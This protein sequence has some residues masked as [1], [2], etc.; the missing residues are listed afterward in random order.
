MIELAGVGPDSRVRFQATFRRF[1]EL[2]DAGVE[3]D[4]PGPELA[5]ATSLAV[6]ALLGRV[7]EEV[8]LGRSA[9]LPSLLPELTYELLVPYV[10]EEAAR[11]EQ[12]RAVASEP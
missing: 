5:R 3:A 11:S 8:F 12:R 6:G 9:E 7:Y 1:V 10:G 2:I 4:G